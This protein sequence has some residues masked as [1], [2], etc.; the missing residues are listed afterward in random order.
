MGHLH[1][2]RWAPGRADAS[3]RSRYAG[4]PLDVLRAEL[5]KTLDAGVHGLCF[6]AYLPGDSP[7]EGT[8]LSEAQIR[9]RMELIAPHCAWIR[10]FSCT[11]GNQLAPRVAHELGLKTLVGAWVG[12]DRDKN[13]AELA[14]L[15]EVARAGHADLIAVGNEVLLR[16]DLPVD[17]LVGLIESVKAAC[18][19]VPV[20]YVDAYYLFEEHPRVVEACDVLFVNCYPFW[21]KYSLEQSIGLVRQMVARA[22]AVAGGRPV[23]ISETGWPTSGA[24]VGAAVPS[25]ENAA[26]YA[27]EVFDWA[28]AQGIPLFYFSAFDEAW[29]TGPEGDCGDAWGFWDQD[30]RRKDDA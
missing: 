14:A 6:S 8:Q 30:G 29:K 4:L 23:V 3:L 16:E 21:E 11:D 22:Q 7:D 2:G 15:L 9:S 25:R 19:G 18:P 17:E 27:L 28:R 1:Q 5:R 20:G 10:T 26:I 13:A 24:P 12:E